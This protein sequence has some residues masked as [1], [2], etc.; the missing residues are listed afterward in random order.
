MVDTARVMCESGLTS[1]LDD[2]DDIV[3]LEDQRGRDTTVLI[4]RQYLTSTLEACVNQFG[5]ELIEDAEINL[6]H[7]VGVQRG[8]NMV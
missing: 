4:I 3:A 7:L 1:H 5:I 2:L 8:L 6:R